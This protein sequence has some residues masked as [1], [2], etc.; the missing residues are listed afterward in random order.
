VNNSGIIERLDQVQP[1]RLS[2]LSP[3]RLAAG[4]IS[5]MDGDPGLGKSTLV[6][7]WA[8]RISRGSPLPDGEPDEPRGVVLLSAEDGLGD[9]IRPRLEAAGADLT[10]IVALTGVAAGVAEDGTIQGERMPSIPADLDVIERAITDVDASLVVFDPFVAYLASTTN[11]YKDQDMRRAMA[12]LAALADRTGVGVILVR[13]LS[14]MQSSNALYRGGGSIAIIAA[15]R[16]GLLVAADPEDPERRVLATT[17]ANLARPPESL[18]FRLLPVEGTDVAR[19]QYEGSSQLTATALLT[20]V[21]DAD[22]RTERDD[23][24][25]WL[26][27]ELAAGPVAAVDLLRAARAVGIAERTLRR[28]KARLGVGSAREGFGRSSVVRWRLPEEAVSIGCQPSHTLPRKNTWQPMQSM[29]AYGPPIPPGLVPD[30]ARTTDDDAKEAEAVSIGCQP[31]HRRPP[32]SGWQPMADVAAY[33]PPSPNGHDDAAREERLQRL[34]EVDPGDRVAMLAAAE[35]EGD[36]PLVRD[37]R[38][39]AQEEVSPR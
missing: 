39:L 19:V 37:L 33:G 15:S 11:S 30:A 20:P 24:A 4:K 38:A 14:K 35:R 6:A 9:T 34:R 36:E 8:A 26:R 21:D 13:H 32:E 22:E 31:V 7:D 18:A 29:A 25:D 17:K 12:P 16:C 3:G 23:A 5:V 27:E 28:A 1:E 10:R 2:W